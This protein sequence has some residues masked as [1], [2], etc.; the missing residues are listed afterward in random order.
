[1]K[2]VTYRYALDGDSLVCIDFFTG[3][4]SERKTYKCPACLQK[5]VPAMG[6]NNQ[7]HF[8]HKGYDL[9][10]T[11]V[12]EQCPYDTYL[13]IISR[14]FFYQ[15]YK[16]SINNQQ[17]ISLEYYESE[18][19]SCDYKEC[20][21]KSTKTF[22]LA[23][24]FKV[25]LEPSKCKKKYPDL[26]LV[27]SN[28]VKIHIL[29]LTHNEQISPDLISSKERI[30]AFQVP[31]ESSLS[32]FN[33]IKRISE[34]DDGTSYYNF[35][36]TKHVDQKRF[37]NEYDD[38]RN[39]EERIVQ[40]KKREQERETIKQQ[41]KY[42]QNYPTSSFKEKYLGPETVLKE[43][44][45][46]SVNFSGKCEFIYIEDFD[47]SFGQIP[48]GYFYL[49]HYKNLKIF[50]QSPK[51]FVD[52]IRSLLK[53]LK[54]KPPIKLVECYLCQHCLLDHH[55]IIN[56]K[57]AKNDHLMALTCQKFKLFLDRYI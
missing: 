42:L 28:G 8:R 15:S 14:T 52:C 31:D 5:M 4:A 45:Y 7:W 12:S 20:E 25:K 18:I 27:S 46:F 9:S 56:C 6:D 16:N 23:T 51:Q 44:Y 43:G 1:M 29:M 3:S 47:C 33:S 35:H 53:F 36:T 34:S 49:K 48:N 24:K 19:C 17:P 30:I 10:V 21:N 57:Q 40:A 37:C 11:S 32:R 22:D 41:E 55:N 13:R 26:F 2:K 50:K 38:L 54:D 39:K